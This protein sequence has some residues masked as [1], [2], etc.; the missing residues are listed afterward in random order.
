MRTIFILLF[1]SSIFY[2][3]NNYKAF[4]SSNADRFSQGLIDTIS[5]RENLVLDIDAK[6]LIKAIRLSEKYLT[7]SYKLETVTLEYLTPAGRLRKQADFIEQK[8]EDIKF[9]RSVFNRL[10]KEIE[11]D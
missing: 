6:D 9:I 11:H 10:K 8:D 3:Q 4:T 1:L 5:A 2:C 7:E